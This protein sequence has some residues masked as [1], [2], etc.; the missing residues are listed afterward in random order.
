MYLLFTNGCDSGHVTVVTLCHSGWLTSFM[1]YSFSCN[2]KVRLESFLPERFTLAHRLCELLMT[3]FWRLT[4][5][6]SWQGGF[7][8]DLPCVER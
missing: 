6:S 2:T 4:K 3:H 8:P 5:G 7:P 1:Q